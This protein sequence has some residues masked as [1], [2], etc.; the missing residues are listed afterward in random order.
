MLIKK[1][2]SEY[3]AQIRKAAIFKLSS[4]DYQHCLVCGAQSN[5]IASLGI[6]SRYECSKCNYR[7]MNR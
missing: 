3:R 6:A 4:G 5:K 2:A 1:K 7:F